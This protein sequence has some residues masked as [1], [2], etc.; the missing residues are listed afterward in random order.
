MDNDWECRFSNL[1]S[2]LCDCEARAHFVGVDKGNKYSGLEGG[3]TWV[4]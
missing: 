1:H 4:I 3:K 2:G